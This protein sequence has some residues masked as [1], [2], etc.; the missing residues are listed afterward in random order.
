MTDSFWQVVAA[1]DREPLLA[2]GDW[3]P[4][5]PVPTLP[6]GYP[7]HGGLAA[8]A[9]VRVSRADLIVV[10]QSCDLANAKVTTAALCP[11]TPLAECRA[12]APQSWSKKVCEQTRRGN[13]P[14]FCMLGS[15]DEPGNPDAA[16]LVDFRQIVALPI[17]YLNRHAQSLETRRR[18][19]SPYVEHFSQA[20]ARFFMRVGLP[21]PIPS[22]TD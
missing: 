17:E 2:Q 22:F 20:F 16:L 7:V 11:I 15:P 19:R 13:Q 12:A 3:F 21:T 6:D 1:A 18:L 4:S 5:C 14:R 9:P 10:T 8:E